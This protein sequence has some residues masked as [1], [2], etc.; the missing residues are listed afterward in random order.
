M[1]AG[2]DVLEVLEDAIHSTHNRQQRKTRESLIEARAAVAELI[3]AAKLMQTTLN[4]HG[5]WEGGCFYY[6][7]TSASE[8]QMPIIILD[9]AVA[10]V[11]GGA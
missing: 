11:S 2:V 1:S 3:E 9:A 6:A 7:W 8:L 10:R 5:D 4:A